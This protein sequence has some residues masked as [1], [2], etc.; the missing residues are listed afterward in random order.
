[1]KCFAR[2]SQSPNDLVEEGS[3]KMLECGYLRHEFAFPLEGIVPRPTGDLNDG[4]T[5]KSG[6]WGM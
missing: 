6:Q 2:C 4:M 1:M 3:V 5:N